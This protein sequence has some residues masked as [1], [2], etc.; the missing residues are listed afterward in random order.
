ML[1]IGGLAPNSAAITKDKLAYLDLPPP[2][3][4]LALCSLTV[5]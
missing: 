2:P 4:H 5:A 3:G 1:S